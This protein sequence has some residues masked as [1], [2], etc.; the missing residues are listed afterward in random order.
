M[1]KEFYSD[2]YIVGLQF[3][4]T[5]TIAYYCYHNSY[6]FYIDHLIESIVHFSNN[7]N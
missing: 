3:A 7:F 6:T 5:N 4:D 1:G 2:L